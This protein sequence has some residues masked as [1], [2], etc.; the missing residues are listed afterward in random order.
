[1][2]LTASQIGG[3]ISRFQWLFRPISFLTLMDTAPL[4][5]FLAYSSQEYW[6]KWTSLKCDPL[7]TRDCLCESLRACE[8]VY[9]YVHQCA[10]VCVRLQVAFCAVLCLCDFLLQRR[11][12]SFCAFILVKR[13]FYTDCFCVHSCHCHSFAKVKPTSCLLLKL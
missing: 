10:W 2:Q 1:M 11:S 13:T 8:C 5:P 7:C 3:A 4:S 12:A 9:Q 6:T